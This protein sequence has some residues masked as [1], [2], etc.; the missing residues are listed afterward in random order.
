LV[1]QSLSID[2]KYILIYGSKQQEKL[3]IH[4]VLLQLLMLMVNYTTTNILWWSVAGL[5]TGL[6]VTVILQI[7]LA[8][9]KRH[10]AE[11]VKDVHDFLTLEQYR[12]TPLWRLVWSCIKASSTVVAV[13]WMLLFVFNQYYI[14]QPNVTATQL[15]TIPASI[16]DDYLFTFVFMT[17][18]RRGD[19]DYLT[20]TISSY[21]EN[22]PENPSSASPYARIQ[23]IIY[24]HFTNHSQYD[25][26]Q[27]YF[28][29]TVKGQRYLRWVRENG[30]ELNQRLHVSK[31]L[32]LVQDTY[33]STYY[34]LMEDDFPVCGRKEWREIENTIYRAQEIDH[35]GVFVGTGGSGLFLK[36]DVTKL[37]TSRLLQDINMPPDIVIQDCLLGKLPECQHCQIVTSK[38]LLMYHI[39]YN[40][41]TSEDRSYRKDE[42]Q[43][44]WRHPFVSMVYF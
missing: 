29:S 16:G 11:L 17:A 3:T 39:G 12:R 26:A 38:R 33:K 34:A 10:D 40:A 1:V 6:M 37:I 44:G 35:C 5:F 14:T 8:E 23:A 27:H 30:D 41:S 18:P 20:R 13:T 28:S 9:K 43:C 21:L 25:A 36:P 19:P 2:D 15:N 32:Q 7:L 31:A 4:K 42:F 24:T 22:W